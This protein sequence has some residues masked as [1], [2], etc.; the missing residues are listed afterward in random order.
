MGWGIT[1]PSSLGLGDVQ[2]F[3]SPVAGGR[4]R[5]EPPSV[6]RVEAATGLAVAEGPG[7]ARILPNI[8]EGSVLY[9]LVNVG[10]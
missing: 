10:R 3:D 2:R 4:W 8:G 9:K 5:A 7:Q 6:L 1:G